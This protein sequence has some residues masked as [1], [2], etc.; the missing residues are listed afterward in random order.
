[1]ASILNV[2]QINNAAGTSA[3]TI[4][5]STG[6][7]SFPNGATLPAGSV[8]QVVNATTSNTSS[9]S[10]TTFADVLSLNITPTSTSSKILLT[11]Q[12]NGAC[13]NRYG[14]VKLYR[15]S[16]QIAVST[17]TIGSRTPVWFPIMG[18]HDASWTTNNWAY[19]QF[20]HYGEHLDAPAST[21]QLTYKITAGN[22]NNTGAT[23]WVN[24][25]TVG[26]Y[27]DAWVHKTVTS[28]TATEIAQ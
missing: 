12:F 26:D 10:G 25:A 23:T 27:N 28:L 24:S 14:A 9:I 17:G 15:G 2:D 21:S 4:D 13:D 8:I 18:N 16:T 19:C 6:K 20:S 3:V 7:P 1:M 11:C 5:P 22:T